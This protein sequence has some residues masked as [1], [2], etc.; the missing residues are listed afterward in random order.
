MEMVNWSGTQGVT[1]RHLAEG[2]CGA[3]IRLVG[4]FLF[5]GCTMGCIT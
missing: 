1:T 2:A 3:W 5:T 4:D